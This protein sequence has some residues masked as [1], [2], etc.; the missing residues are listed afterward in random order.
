MLPV[1]THPPGLHGCRA[2]ERTAP[3]PSSAPPVVAVACLSPLNSSSCLI[4]NLHLRSLPWS[5]NSHSIYRTIHP[6]TIANCEFQEYST[7]S[8]LFFSSPPSQVIRKR[9]GFVLRLHRPS[10]RIIVSSMTGPGQANKKS[11]QG[12]NSHI[13]HHSKLL[14]LLPPPSTLHPFTFTR[15][16]IIKSTPLFLLS[17]L[18]L[19]L[20]S[21]QTYHK[22]FLHTTY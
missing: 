12:Q 5:Y 20:P 7:H 16:N 19:P 2:L 4:G 8:S 11:S 22:I 14:L 10:P 21:F 17:S 15:R 9:N 1:P 18:P 6:T 13:F 3:A